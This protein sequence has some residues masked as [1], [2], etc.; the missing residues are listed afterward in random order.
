MKPKPA[1]ACRRCLQPY[2]THGLLFCVG[3]ACPDGLGT[4]VRK[5]RYGKRASSSFGPRQVAW[6]AE[7][8][9]VLLRG[10]DMTALGRSPECARMARKVEALKAQSARALTTKA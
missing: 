5:P 8:M 4:F 9:R 2:G 3:E 6:L 1:V 10:G 7:T